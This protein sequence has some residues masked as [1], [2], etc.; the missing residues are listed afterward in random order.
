MTDIR[1]FLRARRSAIDPES[2]GIEP[3]G[4]RRVSGLRREELAALAGVSAEYYTRVEQGRVRPSAEVLDAIA[5]ALRLAEPE[6]TYLQALVRPPLSGPLQEHLALPAV[7]ERIFE[8]LTLPAIA[9]GVGGYILAFNSLAEELLFPFS[10]I[11]PELRNFVRIVFTEPSFRDRDP[12]WDMTAERWVS[13]LRADVGRRPSDQR[14]QFLV[15]ELTAGSAQFA[16]LWARQR[17]G[18]KISGHKKMR[19][20]AVGEYELDFATLEVADAKDVVLIVYSAA[21]GTRGDRALGL[22]SGRADKRL[23]YP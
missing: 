7:I 3:S 10:S 23:Q 17:V 1:D 22:L 4:H 21:P 2:V 13:F 6:R 12:D 9:V 15:Q 19:H 8:S 18:E 20:P 11:E 5:G 16:R 14:L